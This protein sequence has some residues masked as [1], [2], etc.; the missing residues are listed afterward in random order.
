MGYEAQGAHN[1]LEYT[2]SLE[3][4]LND[5]LSIQIQVLKS[6][7]TEIENTADILGKLQKATK[8]LIEVMA[9]ALGID[10]GDSSSDSVGAELTGGTKTISVDGKTFE[11][12]IPNN[13]V[14]NNTNDK[15]SAQVFD[16]VTTPSTK[17]TQ[18]RST[19]NTNNE[20]LS[21]EQVKA[22]KAYFDQIDKQEKQDEQKWKNLKKKI[23]K[24]N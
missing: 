16:I 18:D 6:F 9:K 20:S 22:F 19:A 12:V 10:V 24:L 5:S 11:L 21:N 23:Y 15:T 4:G 8:D 17:T 13:K 14:M 3:D 1:D 2:K 7:G